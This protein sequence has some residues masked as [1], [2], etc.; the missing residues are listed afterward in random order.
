VSGLI[1]ANRLVATVAALGVTGQ[2]DL[3]LRG[4]T[5]AV[6]LVSQS[7]VSGSAA[8]TLRRL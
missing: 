4:N 1:E 2:L 8:V 6:T 3:A 5:Q 7:Q